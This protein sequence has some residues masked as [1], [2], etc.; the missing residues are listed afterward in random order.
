[1]ACGPQ[2]IHEL[3]CIEAGITLTPVVTLGNITVTCVGMPMEGECPF[4]T[5]SPT[6]TFDV[7]QEVCVR[8]PITFN[9]TAEVTEKEITCDGFGVGECPVTTP[10]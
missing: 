8:I 7:H 3:A 9:A 6:C 4:D 1:M 10:G 2:I 5:E